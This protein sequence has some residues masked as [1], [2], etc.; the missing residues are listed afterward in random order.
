MEEQETTLEMAERH[1][2][3]MTARVARQREL[4]AEMI[5]D[6]HPRAAQMAQVVLDTMITTLDLAIEHR[7][8]LRS[9]GGRS[10]RTNPVAP[11]A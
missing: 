9:Q 8:C 7:D 1:V 4:L 3:E 6:N 10:C 5:R 11:F 2:H